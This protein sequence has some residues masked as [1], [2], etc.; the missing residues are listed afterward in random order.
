MSDGVFFAFALGLAF[1]AGVAVGGRVAVTRE[2]L[3]RVLRDLKA[4]LAG[5]R[6]LK[7]MRRRHQTELAQVVGVATV[8]VVLLVAVWVSRG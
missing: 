4:N 6:T 2:R 5:Q 8:V 7:Q 1:V 3:R